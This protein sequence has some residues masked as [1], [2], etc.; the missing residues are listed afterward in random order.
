MSEAAAIT[1]CANHPDRETSLRCNRCGKFICAKCAVRTPTGYR[2]QECVRGQQK[3]FETAKTA[4][5]F[6]AFILAAILSAIGGFIATWLG[7]FTILV[8]P[9]AGSLIAEAV[10]SVTGKRRSPSLFLSA[11]AG[12]ALGG[13]IFV[14]QP[15][16]LLLVFR[17]PSA[18]YMILWPA[19]YAGLATSTAYYRLSGIQFRR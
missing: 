17:D 11:A 3:G 16:Y 14:L 4:D 12:V 15:L 10:R 18:L 9:A 2:C 7:F 8:A 6:A 19:V 5:Y 13:A 1:Y